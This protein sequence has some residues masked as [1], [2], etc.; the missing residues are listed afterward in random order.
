[1]QLLGLVVVEHHA[2]Q[3]DLDASSIFGGISPKGSGVT[4][5]CSILGGFAHSKDILPPQILVKR[6]L[7]AR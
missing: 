7:A 4:G 5:Q 2:A 6:V 3:R 1:M